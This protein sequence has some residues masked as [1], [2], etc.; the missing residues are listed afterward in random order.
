MNK[1]LLDT[2]ILIYAI[3]EES[4]YFKVSQTLLYESDIELYTTSK[5]ISEFLSVVTRIPGHSLTLQNAL[6]VIKDFQN[7]F[8]ILF[9]TDQ[10]FSLLIK[11]LLKYKPTGL[12]IHDYEIAS[13]ALANQI[14]NIATFN[15]KDF[16]AIDEVKI[17][18]P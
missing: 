18:I 13:I 10:S 16:K 2:N 12:V 5:N 9:P 14:K 15:D 7:F 17:F 6:L 11:L 1:L 8:T 3:D 4:K